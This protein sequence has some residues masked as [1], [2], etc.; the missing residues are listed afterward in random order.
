[1]M[2]T[3]GEADFLARSMIKY[4]PTDAADRA[5]RRSNAFF[6]LGFIEKSDRWLR[7]AE[8]I[9]KIRAGQDAT[10]D[11]DGRAMAGKPHGAAIAG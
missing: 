7:I 9:K 3:D 10:A 11:A 8:E 1:M 6:V 2:I 4:F 5:A